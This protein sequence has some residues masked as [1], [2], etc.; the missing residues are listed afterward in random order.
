M[1]SRCK[2]RASSSARARASSSDSSLNGRSSGKVSTS[3][4]AS[5]SASARCSSGSP[6]KSATRRSAARAEAVESTSAKPRSRNASFRTMNPR[7][8]Q[9]FEYGTGIHTVR[10]FWKAS[11]ISLEQLASLG[12][13]A[14]RRLQPA[15]RVK[16]MLGPRI[17]AALQSSIELDGASWIASFESRG[18][19]ETRLGSLAGRDIARGRGSAR[20][21]TAG[22]GRFLISLDHGLLTGHR[23]LADG[24]KRV[25][26]RSTRR[27]DRR[28]FGWPHLS[29]ADARHPPFRGY[30][31]N[32]VL[33][34]HA[35]FFA[36]ARHAEASPHHFDLDRPSLDDERRVGSARSYFTD[37]LAAIEHD[38]QTLLRGAPEHD[39]GFGRDIQC[40]ALKRKV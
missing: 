40:Q 4:A 14:A 17:R 13:I 16:R 38:E 33:D 30:L 20:V 5:A 37:D 8:P 27:S 9:A 18:G 34:G 15:V 22:G 1:P 29:G 10:P 7:L 3:Q 35:R 6:C 23:L 36:R 24:T 28:R 25:G 12:A 31:H 2:S 21:G 11:Q 32:A 19:F 39:C 26:R